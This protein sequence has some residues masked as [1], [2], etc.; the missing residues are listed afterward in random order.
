MFKSKREDKLKFEREVYQRATD[1]CNSKKLTGCYATIRKYAH[2][3]MSQDEKLSWEDDLL[4]NP[5][6]LMNL[7]GIGFK[8]ADKVALQLDFPRDHE[9]RILAF[10]GTALDE[11]SKGSTIISLGEILAYMKSQLGIENTGKI[12]DTVINKSDETYRVLDSKYKSTQD[13]FEARFLTK[14]IWYETERDFYNLCVAISKIKTTP[15]PKEVKE[16]IVSKFPFKLNNGQIHSI[17]SFDLFNINILTGYGGTGKTSVTKAILQCLDR[18]K[19]TYTCL[20]PTGISSKIFSQS[21]NT[22]SHTV[23]SFY[24]SGGD[25][26]TAD[27]L[28]LDECSMYSIDHIKMILRMIDIKNPPRLLLIGD[29]GQ[30]SPISVGDPFYSL[31]K[32]INNGKIKGN[33]L[34][35]EEIMRA[36]NETFIPHLCLQ[37]TEGRKYDS[38]CEKRKDLANVHFYKLEQDLSKQILSV[39]NEHNLSFKDTY[40]LIPQRIGEIGTNA[41]NEFL[42]QTLAGEVIHQDKYNVFRKNSELMHVKNNRN[43]N[44]YNG[45]RI[46]LIDKIGEDFICKK[47]D[48]GEEVVYDYET[49]LSE[50]NKSYSCTIHKTQGLTAKNVIFVASSKHSYM[51]SRNLVYTGLSRASEKLIILCD[52]NVLSYAS[53][54]AT[55]DDRITFLGEISKL[56]RSN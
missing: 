52:D 35:L 10:V 43:L 9:F 15:I 11:T 42:D 46:T 53:K 45:E 4:I 37:F 5:Y 41:I 39:V 40:V 36:S 24:F 48:D 23:H 25:I 26:S 16:D 17:N 30:L 27:W 13:I 29:V 2:L 6:V 50:V 8:R 21:T 38:S 19:Y 49:F 20:T 18:C 54:K 1:F 55:I 7:D 34:R 44:I 56:K 51:L 47:L 28:I 32:L 14:T 3:K 22:S 31:I 33:I 12:I